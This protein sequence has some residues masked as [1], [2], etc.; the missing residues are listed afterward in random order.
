MPSLACCIA[1][2]VFSTS[3]FNN[4]G[5]FLF[6]L[7]TRDTSERLAE[8]G[9]EIH[10]ISC[11]SKPISS[12]TTQQV[13]QECREACGGNGY[14][15]SSRFGDL[16]NSND[17]LLTFEGDN[18]VLLQQTSNHL[19]VAYKEFL[20]SRIVPETPLKTLEFLRNYDRLLSQKF[21]A[22]SRQDLLNPSSINYFFSFLI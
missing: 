9:K 17:P 11:A 1:W 18:N 20:K 3:F 21:T 22:K 4:L 16:R 8:L 2:R 12:W 5:E 14:L 13:V 15:K 6:G 7:M 19:I 10:Y